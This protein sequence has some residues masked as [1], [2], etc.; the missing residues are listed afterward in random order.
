MQDNRRSTIAVV[1]WVGQRVE[2]CTINVGLALMM[3]I[4]D[5]GYNVANK[6]VETNFTERERFGTRLSRGWS[7]FDYEFL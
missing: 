4:Q 2:D 7:H 6:L 5:P 3:D 1:K